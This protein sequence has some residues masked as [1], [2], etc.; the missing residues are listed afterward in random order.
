M[1]KRVRQSGSAR[2]IRLMARFLTRH[3]A[4]RAPHQNGLEM[5][6]MSKHLPATRSETLNIESDN[7][8]H[9]GARN[10]VRRRLRTRWHTRLRRRK[11][12]MGGIAPQFRGNVGNRQSIKGLRLV[13]CTNES[14]GVTGEVTIEVTC[15]LSKM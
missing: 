8:T 14:P 11:R 9:H 7:E 13:H 5:V 12:N 15:A 1:L 10:R 4:S 2:L 3:L 6:E